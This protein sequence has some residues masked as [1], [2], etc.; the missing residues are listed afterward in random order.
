V[1][2]HEGLLQASNCG[3][4]VLPQSLLD[5]YRHVAQ[6][7]PQR[8]AALGDLDQCRRAVE[9]ED[10]AGRVVGIE[11]TSEEVLLARAQVVE[12]QGSRQL[13]SGFFFDESEKPSVYRSA[14][15]STPSSGVPSFLLGREPLNR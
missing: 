5:Q 11:A 15:D 6:V 8:L 14:C 3:D 10:L 4:L 7:P 1:I 2:G 13:G 12:R 9:V